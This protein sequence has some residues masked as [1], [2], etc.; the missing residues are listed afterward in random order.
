MVKKR[1]AHDETTDEIE[2]HPKNMYAEPT[3]CPKLN[4]L[5]CL[6]ARVNAFQAEVLNFWPVRAT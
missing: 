6:R 2:I 4:L 3:E 5:W 1:Y